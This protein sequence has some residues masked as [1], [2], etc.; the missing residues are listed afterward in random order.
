MSFNVYS[1]HN[2]GNL[3][4]TAEDIGEVR[5]MARIVALSG[6][7]ALYRVFERTTKSVTGEQFVVSFSVLNGTVTELTEPTIPSAHWGS[8]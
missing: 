8:R 1:N 6:Q 2:G 4:W 7:P 5:D 3:T